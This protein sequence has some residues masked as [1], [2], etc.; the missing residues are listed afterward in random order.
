VLHSYIYVSN[1]NSDTVSVIRDTD[2]KVIHIIPLTDLASRFVPPGFVQPNGIAY[3]PA[4]NGK[5]YVCDEAS[6]G[7]S[8]ISP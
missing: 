5:V 6:N 7:L 2:D 4:L 1:A 8:I 3:D